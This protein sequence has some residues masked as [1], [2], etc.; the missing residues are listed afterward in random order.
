MRVGSL[1]VRGCNNNRKK[2][3]IEEL[4]CARSFYV[5]VLCETKLKGKGEGSLGINWVIRIVKGIR[6]REAVAIMVK[7]EWMDYIDKRGES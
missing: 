4:R 3:E 5:S 2:C 7:G 6:G 1:N